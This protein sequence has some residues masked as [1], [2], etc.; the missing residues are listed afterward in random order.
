M[1]S[2]QQHL[3][4]P[5]STLAAGGAC[6]AMPPAWVQGGEMRRGADERAKQWV[7]WLECKNR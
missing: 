7:E 1:G 4:G 5:P 2:V 6:C 3:S